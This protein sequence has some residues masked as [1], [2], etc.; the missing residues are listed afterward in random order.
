MPHL[1]RLPILHVHR[2]GTRP[3]V[4][5]TTGRAVLYGPD[6]GPVFSFVTLEPA[7]RENRVGVSCIP[8]GIYKL[9]AHQSPRFGPTIDIVGEEPKRNLVII[10]AGNDVQHTRGCILPGSD[11]RNID[12]D[13]APEVVNSKRTLERLRK[14]IGPAGWLVITADA[15]HKP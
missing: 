6:G 11:F 1:A 2:V 5:P 9:R 4:P 15:P 10:H 12:G 14:L 13:P 8:P 7:W 3:D